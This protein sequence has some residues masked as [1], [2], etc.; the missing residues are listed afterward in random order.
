MPSRRATADSRL[1]PAQSNASGVSQR[2][3]QELRVDIADPGAVKRLQLDQPHDLGVRGDHRVW[4][5]TQ[6]PKDV[7]AAAEV[8][9]GELTDN[10]RM[11]EDRP[12][13]EKGGKIH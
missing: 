4:Q 6:Q 2:C 5:I 13:V 3:S 10:P 9:Q 12:H 7:R 1:S 8:A 11:S